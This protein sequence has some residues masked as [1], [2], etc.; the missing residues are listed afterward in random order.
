MENRVGENVP[1]Q[2]KLDTWLKSLTVVQSE[3]VKFCITLTTD[4]RR[5]MLRSRK[6]SE[7]LIRRVHEIATKK[8]LSI[9]G[10]GRDSMLSD[11]DL[12]LKLEPF[13]SLLTLCLQLVED[14]QAQADAEAWQAFLAYYSVLSTMSAHDPE[15]AVALS[16]V[17]TA[18]RH[19]RKKPEP[20]PAPTPGK[21]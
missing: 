4:E 1:P 2:A 6:E 18:M 14:T 3:L 17:V 19:T 21:P 15:I 10:I 8:G 9:P 20:T 5:R 11:V 7:G 16:P 12:S 13:I